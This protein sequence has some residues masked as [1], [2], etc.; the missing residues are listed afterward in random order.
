LPSIVG[1]FKPDWR[2]CRCCTAKKRNRSNRECSGPRH[3]ARLY[4]FVIAVWRAKETS[5]A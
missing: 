1:R 5:I 3:C 2:R 4:H